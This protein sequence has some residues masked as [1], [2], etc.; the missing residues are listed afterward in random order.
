METKRGGP[1]HGDSS[2]KDG[3]LNIIR[4]DASETA[5]LFCLALLI[6]AAN[7]FISLRLPATSAVARRPLPPR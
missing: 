7:I 3:A 4:H 2:L 5:V 1:G 6:C